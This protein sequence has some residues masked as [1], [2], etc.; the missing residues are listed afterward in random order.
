MEGHLRSNHLKCPF[1]KRVIKMNEQ[2]EKFYKEYM[3]QANKREQEREKERERKKREDDEFIDKLIKE[4]EDAIKFENDDIIDKETKFFNDHTSII[5]SSDIPYPSK[6][7]ISNL[8]NTAI[9]RDKVYKN[10]AKTWHPDRFMN[11]YNSRI[12]IDD[13]KIILAKITETFQMI[14]SIYK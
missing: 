11:K 13:R 9:D 7:T 1:N 6:N 4:L 2:K 10:L 12:H 8:I 14:A 3:E 5:R